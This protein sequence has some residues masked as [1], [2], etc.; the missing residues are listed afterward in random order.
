MQ[1][2]SHEVLRA[3]RANHKLTA[4]PGKDPGKFWASKQM[5]IDANAMR[6]N[7]AR[8]VPCDRTV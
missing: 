1:V 5:P 4:W 8:E 6:F 7:A 3:T 2:T